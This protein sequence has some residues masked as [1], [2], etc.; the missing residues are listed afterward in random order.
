MAKVPQLEN[1]T[2]GTN[3]AKVPLLERDKA[4]KNGKLTQMEDQIE[5][6]AQEIRQLNTEKE[7]LILR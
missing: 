3:V 2:D 6:K 7:T 1:D 4:E 5:R